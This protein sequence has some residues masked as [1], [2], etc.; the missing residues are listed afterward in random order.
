MG[1]GIKVVPKNLND[2]QMKRVDKIESPERAR[3]VASRISDRRNA[4]G[5]ENPRLAPKPTA[6]PAMKKGGKVAKKK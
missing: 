5:A 3:K 1:V 2:R 6:A 4:R